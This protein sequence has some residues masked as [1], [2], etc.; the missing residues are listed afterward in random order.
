MDDEE[1]EE[2][3]SSSISKFMGA[4]GFRMPPLRLQ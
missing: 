1:E 2:E 3:S 4:L